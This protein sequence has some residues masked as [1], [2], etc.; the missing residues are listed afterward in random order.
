MLAD[1]LARDEQTETGA[2][3]WLLG[4][5][6]GLEDVLAESGR[7]AVSGVGDLHGQPVA[8]GP[9]AH[10]DSPP[11]RGGIEGIGQEVEDDLL[12][13]AGVPPHHGGSLLEIEDQ[14]YAGRR[15][16]GTDEVHRVA[17]QTVELQRGELA[18]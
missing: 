12:E 7:D 9:G 13:L 4:R 17:Y 10:G 18:T 11:G 5:E 2:M 1:D 6:E 8:R 14:T 16:A 15:H 3:T